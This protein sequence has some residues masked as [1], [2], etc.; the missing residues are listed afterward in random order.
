MWRIVF[1]EDQRGK[2]LPLE[3]IDTLP[4]VDQAKIRNALRLC[5]N[6]VWLWACRMP[7]LF[8]ESC[9]S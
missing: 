4:V 5:K 8:K 1:Y 6:S 7:D 9:G 2:C 3:F